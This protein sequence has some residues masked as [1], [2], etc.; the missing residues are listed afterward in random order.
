MNQ[1]YHI[2]EWQTSAIA[3]SLIKLNLKSLKDEDAIASYYFG[4]LSRTER[5]NDGRYRD[6]WLNRYREPLKGGWGIEGY[7]P[8][9][10]TVEPELRSFKPDSPRIAKN[11]KI[12][13]YDTPIKSQ[14]APIL[15]RISYEIASMVF[16]SAGLNFLDLLRKYAPDEAI[17]DIEDSAE[18]P[19]FWTA[20]MAHPEIPLSITEG[21][22]K[23]LAILSQGRCAIAVT[24]ITTWREKGGSNKVHPWIALFARRRNFYLTFDQDVKPKTV[25][26]VNLQSWKL[27]NALLAAGAAK[28]RRISWSGTAK[29]IDDFVYGLQSRYGDRA[30]TKILRKCYQNARDYRKVGVQKPLPGKIKKI[31]KQYLSVVDLWD[32]DKAHFSYS[33]LFELLKIDCLFGL[34]FLTRSMSYTIDWRILIIMSAKGTG[35]TELLSELIERDR[36]ELETPTINLSHLE[37]LARELGFRLDLPYRTEKDSISARNALG[38]SLCIDSFSPENSVPFN[39]EQ[40][41]DAGLTID[42]FTQVLEHLTFGTT[43]VKKYRQLITET[44]G[45]KLADCWKNYKPIRLLDA[46]ANTETV[47]LIYDLIGISCDWEVDTEELEQNTLTIVNEYE[48]PKGELHFYHEKSPKQIKSDL[49]ERMKRRENLLILSSSQKAR[50]GDGTYNLEK[51]AL[52][53]YKSEEILRIDS[54]TTGDPDHPAFN[55]TAEAIAALTKPSL[56]KVSSPKNFQQLNL[57]SQN[58]EITPKPK[59]KSVPIKVVIASPT[60]CTGISLVIMNYFNA[61]FSFQ[62]GNIS[63]NS[64]RQQLVRLRDFAVPRYLWCPK[65]G[66]SFVGSKSTN[67]VELITD[68]KGESII[69]LSLL[70]HKAAERLIESNICPLTKHWARIGAKRNKDSYHYREIL[71]LDLEEE[72][73]NIIDRYPDDDNPNLKAVWE[74]RKQIKQESVREDNQTTSEASEI[75][76]EQARRLEQRKDLTLQQ[77]HQLKKHRLAQKYG[78]KE[79][80]PKLIEADGKKLYSSLQLRFWL[81]EGRQF[82]EQRDRSFIAGYQKRNKGRLFIPDLNNGTYVAKVKLLEMLR[83]DRFIQPGSEWNNKSPE[84]LELRDFIL[85]DLVRFNQVLSTGI[86][87][88]DSPVSMLQKILKQVGSKLTY[89]RNERDGDKRLR[90][91]GAAVS[92]YELD[93]IEGQIIESWFSFCHEQ[94]KVEVA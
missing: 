2:E 72:G 27:G 80:T 16:R 59:P 18:C 73:W 12:I 48:P 61:V 74:Q 58:K 47:E 91:Y 67:P 10:M 35:K 21:G 79:V 92:R 38:Y 7:D 69:T 30:M 26:N 4:N 94:Y 46:D 75:T 36:S 62:A 20:V 87:I 34:A 49:I 78:I 37:R 89:L 14:P 93:A 29:G 83:L 50:S 82:L 90:I 84:L 6:K 22:K 11:G 54:T 70:G 60:I 33:L 88:A 55:I 19:W 63:P 31:N 41:I 71:H 64:V 40:W 66:K 68:Q 25:K 13:K 1:Q 52:K 9:D 32:W 8:T 24:S 57:L 65:V 53:Y 45:Q 51:L 76:G 39:P 42:E 23:A 43:E 17:E 3:L 15:P 28:V 81:K 77:Q 86:A 56:P 44:L 85:K 5:R